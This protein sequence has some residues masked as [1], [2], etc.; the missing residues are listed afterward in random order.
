VWTTHVH[1]NGGK[2]DDHLLPYRGT[3][4]WDAAMM[5][6]QKVGYEGRLMFEVADTGDPLEVLKGAVK[7]RER[8]EKTFVT[9]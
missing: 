3:I 2:R 6:T 9:F 7:A 5:E 1:D 4:D 8:L